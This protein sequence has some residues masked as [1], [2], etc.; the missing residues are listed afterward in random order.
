MMELIQSFVWR[1]FIIGLPTN[2]LNKIFMRLHEDIDYKNYL[3]SIQF[4]LLTKKGNQ[5][6][7][8]NQEVVNAL[9]EKDMYGIKPKNRIYFLER[10]E[11]HK[12]KEMV[13][14]DG[15]SNITIEH[16]FPQNPEAKWKIELGENQYTF[17]KENHL[18]TIANLTLSGNNGKL[19]NKIFISKKEMNV[20]GKEQGY[21]Y[22]RLWLN[23]YLSTID[24]WS[25]DEIEKRF[26]L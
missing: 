10:L 26:I 22:S 1:R 4:S 23:R 25:K 8:R 12:N 18:N 9:I 17:I 13:V 16:I 11:N 2:A 3:R 6:F 15:N 5:R 19:G 24:K 14:V 21:K 20:D 7:P